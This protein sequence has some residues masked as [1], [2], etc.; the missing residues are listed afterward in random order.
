MSKRNFSG[1]GIFGEGGA[2]GLQLLAAIIIVIVVLIV[3][4]GGLYIVSVFRSLLIEPIQRGEFTGF[5]IIVVGIFVVMMV[6][7]FRRRNA[8]EYQADQIRE[9]LR[10]SRRGW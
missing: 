4:G 9:N 6:S 2:R 3:F 10:R 1:L 7:K 5:G 8:G